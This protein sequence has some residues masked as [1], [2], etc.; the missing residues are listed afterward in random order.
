MVMLCL[1]QRSTAQH[2]VQLERLIDTWIGMV[3]QR[4]W[5]LSR[6]P[7]H[8]RTTQLTV[9]VLV[10]YLSRTGAQ[11]ENRDMI[12]KQNPPQQHDS[13]FIF[14]F[15]TFFSFNGPVSEKTKKKPAS[16][17]RSVIHS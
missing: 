1:V 3:V 8:R 12:P 14:T 2:T 9:T 11:T 4:F 7:G 6:I 13:F 17:P 15:F 16:S 10:P 5:Y